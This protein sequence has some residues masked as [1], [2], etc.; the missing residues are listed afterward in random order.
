[1]EKEVELKQLHNM[2]DKILEK[3][4]FLIELKA[5]FH[6]II[7][8][9]WNQNED[10]I[11]INS[12]L[13]I[14]K[15]EYIYRYM[16][17]IAKIDSLEKKFLVGDVPAYINFDED[18]LNLIISNVFKTNKKSDAEIL[19]KCLAHELGHLQNNS[20]RKYFFTCGSLLLTIAIVEGVAEENAKNN[21]LSKIRFIDS[22]FKYHINFLQSY[23]C[24]IPQIGYSYVREYRL[25]SNFLEQLRAILPDEIFIDITQKWISNLDLYIIEKIDEQIQNRD[26][27][28]NYIKN[29]ITVFRKKKKRIAVKAERI[30][31]EFG[32]VTLN[33]DIEPDESMLNSEDNARYRQWDKK[34]KE[35]M[36][37]NTSSKKNI[38]Q[39]Q[40]DFISIMSAKVRKAQNIEEVLKI[41]GDMEYYAAYMPKITNSKGE[42]VTRSELEIFKFENAVSEITKYLQEAEICSV[43]TNSTNTAGE[44]PDL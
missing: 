31:D 37:E 9:I 32:Y 38:I 2:L 34:V 24:N 19:K 41:V 13:S 3:K 10:Y 22:K 27:C 40:R 7:D 23:T 4:P 11:Q 26:L 1:M 36:K 20:L 29:A 30:L 14:S 28:E 21:T 35:Y 39:M 8:D 15:T 6:E 25:Y 44:E 43:L 18:K 42:D 16:K 17:G 5:I 33:Y 12:Q